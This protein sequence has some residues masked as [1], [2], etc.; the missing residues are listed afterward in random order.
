MFLKT[1]ITL[2]SLRW[3]SKAAHMWCSFHVY[4]KSDSL[5][6]ENF[7]LLRCCLMAQVNQWLTW[8][9][10]AEEEESED[11]D[12]WGTGQSHVLS[13]C[14]E[15]FIFYFI[16]FSS[17]FVF[18]P[19]PQLLPSSLVYPLQPLLQFILLCLTRSSQPHYHLIVFMLFSLIFNLLWC[20]IADVLIH[21]NHRG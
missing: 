5:G 14:N 10:T 18:M 13:G 16:Q 20:P 12:Y 2:D 17:F 8:L 15:R 3:L 11:E 19:F 4:S 7:V 21:F 6:K 1:Y 9:E